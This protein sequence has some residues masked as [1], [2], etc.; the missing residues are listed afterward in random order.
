MQP[1]VDT[2]ASMPPGTG[3]EIDPSKAAPADVAVN[4]ENV[5]LVASTFIEL[6]SSSLPALPG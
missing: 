6:M 1:L 3:Y 2:M 5:E 4:K